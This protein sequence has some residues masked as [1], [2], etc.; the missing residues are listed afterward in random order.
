[1]VFNYKFS[2]GTLTREYILFAKTEEERDIW[3]QSFLKVIEYNTLTD[4]QFNL[5][6]PP[7]IQAN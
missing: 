5:L 6:I 1:M 7:I 4:G 3:V 2:L